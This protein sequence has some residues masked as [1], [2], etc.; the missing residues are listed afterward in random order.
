MNEYTEYH[1]V[2]QAVSSNSNKIDNLQ[3]QFNSR[4]MQKQNFQRLNNL[5]CIN[6]AGIPQSSE[7]GHDRLI[8]HNIAK[9]Y[10]IKLQPSDI[11]FIRRLSSQKTSSSPVA[12]IFVRFSSRNTVEELLSKYYMAIKSI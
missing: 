8:I 1:R 11:M 4:K 10:G 7:L 5:N 6:V 2:N 3:L 9:F 12:P